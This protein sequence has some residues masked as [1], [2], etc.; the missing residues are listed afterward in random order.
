[1]SKRLSILLLIVFVVVLH[2]SV[3]TSVSADGGCST[4]IVKYGDNLFRISQRFGV[5]MHTI[6]AANGIYNINRIYAGQKLVICQGST[7][8]SSSSSSYTQPSS[9]A[10]YSAST[11]SSSQVYAPQT[12]PYPYDPRSFYPP[13]VAY[14]QIYQIPPFHPCPFIAN[15]AFADCGSFFLELAANQPVLFYG[16]C[17]PR[18][19]RAR[20]I[21]TGDMVCAL[22]GDRW[23]AI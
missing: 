8:T 16:V 10:S 18:S 1:M 6:A 9:T 2:L 21:G 22:T 19:V 4:Y 20:P 12:Y 23:L 13:A 3:V 11:T 15:G 17:E 7:S 14:P 5:N